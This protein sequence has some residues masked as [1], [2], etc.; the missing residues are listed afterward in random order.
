LFFT[1]WT[2]SAYA[3][4]TQ[5]FCTMEQGVDRMLKAADIP[6][7]FT[8][9]PVVRDIAADVVRDKLQEKPGE[10]IE[11]TWKNIYD[12]RGTINA[13][14]CSE[15]NKLNC[16]G[17]TID[18]VGSGLT[19]TTAG[20][21]LMGGGLALSGPPGFVL[22]GGMAVTQE[23]FQCQPSV[24]KMALVAGANVAIN[25]PWCKAPG[26]NQACVS[27][28]NGIKNGALA[29]ARKIFGNKVAVKAVKRAKGGLEVVLADAE[30]AAQTAAAAVPPRPVSSQISSRIPLN[31]G[32]P[33]I[34]FDGGGGR[35]SS[36]E[37]RT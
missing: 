6:D 15:G 9:K 11:I 22:V 17:Q 35:I 27:M 1:L 33:E 13:W 30:K 8:S 29:A 4:P 21:F 2:V 10:P 3:K 20:K 24:V 16:V 34:N 32:K 25:L 28:S 26:I 14:L 5:Q 7:E 23:T 12:L 19:G 36:G 18:A 37:P 31:S